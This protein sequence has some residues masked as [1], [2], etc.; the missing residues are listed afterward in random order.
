[1]EE[2]T[3]RPDKI[4]TPMAV[5]DRA[6]QFAPFESLGSMEELLNS[7]AEGRNVGDLE[8]FDLFEEPEYLYEP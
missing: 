4:R 7:V 2:R 8:H 1:M 6:K 3:H 5:P